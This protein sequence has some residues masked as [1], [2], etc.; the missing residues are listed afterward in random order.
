MTSPSL[1]T[2]QQRWERV[3]PRRSLPLRVDL[4]GLA[5]VEDVGRTNGYAKEIF[6]I[7]HLSDD[8]K[9]SELL[10]LIGELL[11]PK[12]VILGRRLMRGSYRP[13]VC[14]TI[15]FSRL[16]PHGKLLTGGQGVRVVIAQHA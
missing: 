10:V 4:C 14:D 7:C 6:L 1:R 13:T 9:N 5:D 11:R 16:A 15:G 8:R 3:R 12:E 2:A